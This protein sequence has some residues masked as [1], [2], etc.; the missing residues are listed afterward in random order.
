MNTPPAWTPHTF[1]D[2]GFLYLWNINQTKWTGDDPKIVPVPYNVADEETRKAF[3]AMYAGKVDV[4]I[5]GDRRITP[6]FHGAGPYIL[7]PDA[8]DGKPNP[9]GRAFLKWLDQNPDRYFGVLLNYY[10][11]RRITDAG[12]A[13][14]LKYRDRFVGSIAGESLGYFYVKDDAMKAATG[15]T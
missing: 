1:R 6:I 12:K 3:E 10:G 2:K 15:A 7:E 4:P 13:N 11:D 5:F 14:F 9:D 8:K